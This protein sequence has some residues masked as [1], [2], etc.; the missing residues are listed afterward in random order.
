MKTFKVTLA[1]TILGLLLAMPVSA[2]TYRTVQGAAVDLNCMVS[3][4]EKR[5][6]GIIV[7]WDTFSAS[8]RSALETR[9]DALKAAWADSNQRTRR[10]SIKNA[11]KAFRSSRKNAWR[12]RRSAVFSAWKTFKAER[13]ACGAVAA[14]ETGT[15]AVDLSVE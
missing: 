1:S 8:M 6:N 11:W 10:S 14:D 13:R 4:V 9:R 15:Q 12:T 5:D 7:A 2:V 3:A